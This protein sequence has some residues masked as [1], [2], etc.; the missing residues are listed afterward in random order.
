MQKQKEI[1]RKRINRIAAQERQRAGR[2]SLRPA[3]PRPAGAS[4]TKAEITAAASATFPQTAP[5]AAASA[6]HSTLVNT[7]VAHAPSSVQPSSFHD[8]SS[9]MLIF[10]L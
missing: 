6:R 8:F 9:G 1:I 2:S 5:H 10:V 7:P 4:L 3:L